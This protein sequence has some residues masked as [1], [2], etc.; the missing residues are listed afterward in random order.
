MSRETS[1][2]RTLCLGEIQPELICPF[3][4][5]SDEEKE[6]L[7]TVRTSVAQ[8][9]ES[10]I[11]DFVEWDRTGV[12][13]PEFIDELKEFGLFSLVIPEDDGG[14]GMGSAAYSR[15]LQELARFDA[16]TAVTVGAHSSIG[17]R[18]LLL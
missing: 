14:L 16:A 3:P 17:M 8:L 2:M 6:T 4:S 7:D 1:F 15:T 18:G 10:H 11:S 5:L 9:M 13:P 12:F